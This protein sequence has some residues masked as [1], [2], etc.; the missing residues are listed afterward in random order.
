M[1][2]QGGLLASTIAQRTQ[3]KLVE[4][5]KSG[6]HALPIVSFLAAKLISYTI[7]GFLLGYL[8]SFFQLSLKTQVIL[9]ITVAIFMVGTALNL[10]HVHPIFRYFVI[11]PPRLLTRFVRKE[12]RSSGL[13]A[14]A[15][16]GVFT[17]FIPCGTTQA[18]MAL[19]IASGSP[20]T[21]ALILFAFTLGTTPVFFLLGYF[22]TRLGEVFAHQFAKIA[23]YSIM[24]LTVFNIN[25]V[26]ALSG[27]TITL[28][29][30]AKDVYCSITFCSDSLAFAQN[31]VEGSA[32]SDVTIT[33]RSDGY[34]PNDFA[35]K[36][37]STVTLH[38]VNNGGGGCAQAFTIPTLGIQKI[39]TPGNSDTVQFTAPTNTTEIAFMCGMG[40]YKG[41][42]RVI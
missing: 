1:A 13:F 15:L 34:S 35:V 21:G 14:P 22:T 37:G 26:L 36:S 8:G 27:S 17:V 4:K 7:L 20:I 11:Q 32:V 6:G 28:D 30:L 31:R 9:Q 42:I 10:L 41:R 12:S 39:V 2:I 38:L 5:T 33:I 16:L 3:E 40:M 18:M 25:N 29:S 23:A 19:S 24:L